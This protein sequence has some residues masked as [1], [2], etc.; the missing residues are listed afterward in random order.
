MQGARLLGLGNKSPKVR[1]G[2]VAEV[3]LFDGPI[4]EVEQAQA[5]AELAVVVRSTMR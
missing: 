4:A 1:L 2:A 5:Q 3:V